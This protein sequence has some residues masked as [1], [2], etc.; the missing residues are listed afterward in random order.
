MSH[1]LREGYDVALTDHVFDKVRS[2]DM[3]LREFEALLGGGDVIETSHMDEGLKELVLLIDWF[4]PL[5]VVVIVDDLR[6]EER[7]VTVYEP[8]RDRWST[9]FRVRKS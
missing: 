7:I 4:R 8:D 3:T 1:P 9:D 6:E 2:I 5:H